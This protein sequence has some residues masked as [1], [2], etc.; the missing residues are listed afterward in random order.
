MLKSCT[1]RVFWSYCLHPRRFLLQK[2]MRIHNAGLDVFLSEQAGW[3]IQ[4]VLI[5]GYEEFGFDLPA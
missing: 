1:P 5:T 3:D 2:L 4:Q